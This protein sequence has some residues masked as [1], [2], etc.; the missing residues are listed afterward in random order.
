VARGGVGTIITGF[1]F[2]SRAGRAMQP[3]QCGIDHNDKVAPWAA[4]VAEVRRAAPDVKLIMQLAHAGRQT[5]R[6]ITGLPVQGASNR[7]C[8]YFRQKV[9]PLTDADIHAVI[10]EFASAARRAQAAGFDGIE[11]HAA[12]GYLLHQFLSP[13]TNRR[14]DAWGTEPERFLV[15]TVHA[16]RAACGDSFPIWVKLSAAED[17]TPGLCPDD[18]MRTAR[19]LAALEVDAIEISYG[20][21][22][23]ALNIIRGACPVDVVLKVNP[24]FNRIPVFVRP[25]WKTFFSGRY[26]RRLTAFTEGYNVAAAAWIK[27][28]VPSLP[29]LVTGGLRSR[30]MMEACIA[31]HGL[32]GVSLCRPLVCEPDLPQRFRAGTALH[33]ACC[34]CNLCTVYCDSRT[35][36]RCYANAKSR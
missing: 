16:V 22:E 34:N 23:N 10:A 12:H 14:R 24:L 18:T 21:M 6:Q 35:P 5:R 8:S 32:D 2:T 26:R 17:N 9:Q 7:C 3:C 27:R 28:A 30:A 1:V 4:I 25:F 29:V 11:L 13:W 20:T 36:L 15:E 19:R 33:S 31:E